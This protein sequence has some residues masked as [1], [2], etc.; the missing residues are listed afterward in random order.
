MEGFAIMRTMKRGPALPQIDPTQVPGEARIVPAGILGGVGQRP[1]L[2]ER[3]DLEVR[4]V[5]ELFSRSRVLRVSSPREVGPSGS[6]DFGVLSLSSGPQRH[7]S[8]G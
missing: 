8:S 6:A 5:V 3:Q 7:G 4:Q 1:T 2:P